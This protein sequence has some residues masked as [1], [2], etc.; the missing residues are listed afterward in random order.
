MDAIFIIGIFVLFV[1]FL[2]WF[3]APRCGYCGERIGSLPSSYITAP[4][5]IS[6]HN[7]CV[8]GMY[9]RL[10][11]DH[12]HRAKRNDYMDMLDRQHE[13]KNKTGKGLSKAEWKAYRARH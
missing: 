1:I 12:A 9:E 8:E 13:A 11:N 5:S 2:N 7:K 10:E 3:N 6:V 4:A